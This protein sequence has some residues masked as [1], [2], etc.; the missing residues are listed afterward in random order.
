[1]RRCDSQYLVLVIR[2]TLATGKLADTHLC[3]AVFHGFGSLK[4]GCTL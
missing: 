1:M 4:Y 3:I 2:E